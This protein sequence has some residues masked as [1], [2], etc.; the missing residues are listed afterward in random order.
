L[1]SV[2]V[3]IC[4]DTRLE[5]PH[6][7]RMTS[8]GSARG[9]GNGPKDHGGKREQEQLGDAATVHDLYVG[10]RSRDVNQPNEGFG[11]S[12]GRGA[13]RRAGGARG[14][15]GSG[16]GG[17]PATGIAARAPSTPASSAPT[18]TEIRTASGDSCTVRPYTMGCRTWFSICW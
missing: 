11:R 5:R 4:E 8:G 15:P 14:W 1:T 10:P 6:L 3:E 2:L 9:R 17:P 16:L 18:S 13:R 7:R 12:G